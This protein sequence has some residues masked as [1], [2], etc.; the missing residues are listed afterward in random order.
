MFAVGTIP[1]SIAL[2]LAM[3]ILVDARSPDVDPAPVVLHPTVL[4]M[5]AVANIWLFFFTPGYGPSSR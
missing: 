2:A 3:A 1:V 4:P 5:I